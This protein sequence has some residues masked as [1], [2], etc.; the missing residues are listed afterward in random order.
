MNGVNFILSPL[1]YIDRY[2]YTGLVIYKLSIYV[3]SSHIDS[4]IGC[5]R[6][7]NI[8]IYIY[9]YRFNIYKIVI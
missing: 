7:Y 2:I 9:T 6:N 1:V 5:Y 4:Y 3:S 8:Y